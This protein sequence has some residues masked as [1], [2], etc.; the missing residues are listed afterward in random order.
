VLAIPMA[1]NDGRQDY[2]RARIIASADGVPH[3]E[4]GP[5]QDSSLLN[6]L[7]DADCLVIR[8]PHAA[9]AAAGTPCRIIRLARLGA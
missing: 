3:V 6:A 2:V 5:R 1:A 9:A 4:P 8:P 7:S